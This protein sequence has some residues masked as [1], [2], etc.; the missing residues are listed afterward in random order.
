LQQR[1][2]IRVRADKLLYDWVPRYVFLLMVATPE[3]TVGD[4]SE[5]DYQEPISK[6]Q[7]KSKGQSSSRE[8]DHKP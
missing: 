3:L 6:V 4:P 8:Q 7:T 2:D 1:L 5:A